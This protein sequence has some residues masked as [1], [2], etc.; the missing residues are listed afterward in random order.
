MRRRYSRPR[1]L[2]AGW[3]R[4]RRPTGPPY[5]RSATTRL[6][7]RLALREIAPLPFPQHLLVPARLEQT[8]VVGHADDRGDRRCRVGL[9]LEER[10]DDLVADE[11][12][13]IL[14]PVGLGR[15]PE[16]PVAGVGAV[17]LAPEAA[18]E[19]PLVRDTVGVG[20]PVDVAARDL[21]RDEVGSALLD[22]AR[23]QGVRA[24]ISLRV[25]RCVL[26]VRQLVGDEVDQVVERVVTR[27]PA[28]CRLRV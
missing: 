3:T 16:E 6:H 4:P 22:R 15:A 9:P 19:L 25:R 26:V 5:R 28:R 20:G 10:L 18:P 7:A 2:S 24:L 1:T 21:F 23:E 27:R 12:A 13:E 17:H 14:R 8:G 11:V